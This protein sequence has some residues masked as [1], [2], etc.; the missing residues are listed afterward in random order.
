MTE[1]PKGWEQHLTR[2]IDAASL[3]AF[4]VMFGL[5]MAFGLAR[6]VLQGWIDKLYVGPNFFFKYPGFEWVTVPDRAGLYTLF[7]VLFVSALLIAL[8]LFYRAATIVFFFAFA[9]LQ[10]LDVTNYLNHYYF[11]LLLAGWLVVLPLHR[12]YSLDARR[13]PALASATLPAWC[14][15]ALRFQIGVLY[16]Y[17]GLAKL[18]VDW[19]F[20]A[21]P[22]QIW[23]LNRSE[24]PVL[25]PLFALPATAYLMSWAGFFYDLSIPFWLSFRRTRPYAYL[26]VLTFH[27][28]THVL[29]EIGMF[30]LI[31]SVVTLLFFDPSWPRR[32]V[33]SAPAPIAAA[34]TSRLSRPALAV[35]A[36]Y[37]AVQV[38]VPLRHFVVPGDVLWNEVGMR[39][40]WKVMVREK[41]G[42]ISYRVRSKATGREWRV[43][44]HEYLTWRQANEMSG[45]PDLI[46]QLAHHIAK[47]FGAKGLGP[48]EVYADALV[49]WNGRA[50]ARLIDPNI[51]LS[52]QPDTVLTAQ[53]IL[54][55]PPEPPIGRPL[56]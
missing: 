20:H 22:L 31:M 37:A 17:A 23:L 8:G 1:G 7:A 6:F 41:N 49:S 27:F 56:Y 50:P 40:A 45:Q 28:V 43:S 12:H 26:V 38:L 36:V 47:D 25:G 48:V 11:V 14:L 2:P 32:F 54:A 30:P 13:R 16:V 35:F 29:F 4:R 24:T 33:R 5:M 21:Q 19:L 46:L 51:D 39:Y 34:S 53:Y 55:E 3:V 42:S 18:S 44:A 10:L 9:Y 52:A 15:Y